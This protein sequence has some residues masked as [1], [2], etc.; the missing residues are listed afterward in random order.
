MENLSSRVAAA[1]VFIWGRLA[2]YRADG[3]SLVTIQHEETGASRFKPRPRRPR[4]G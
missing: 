2:K 1:L 4:Q 3:A